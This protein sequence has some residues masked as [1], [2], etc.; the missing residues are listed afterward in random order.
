MRL[1]ETAEG[2][3]LP[4]NL[5]ALQLL[6]A[7]LPQGASSLCSWSSSQAQQQQQQEQ[8]LP[9][10]LRQL[11]LLTVF[12]QAVQLAATAAAGVRSLQW[13]LQKQRHWRQA[14]QSST[15]AMLLTVRCKLKIRQP[16]PEPLLLLLQHVL[17]HQ[18][19]RQLHGRH[20]VAWLVLWTQY[21]RRTVMQ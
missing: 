5:T 2:R 7:D 19:Y 20:P 12:S 8:M 11:L 4:D 18:L 1:A 16:R 10:L 13:M 14:L 9:L 6:P 17:L 15:P 21:C 3:P